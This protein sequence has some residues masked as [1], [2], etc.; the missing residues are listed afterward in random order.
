MS[1]HTLTCTFCKKSEHD[2]RKL[3]AGPGVYIC[4][5]CVEIAH[6]IVTGSDAA[7]PQPAWSSRVACWIR[8]RLPP[9][10]R[11]ASAQRAVQPT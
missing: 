3:V 2:V 8:A 10:G 7:A 5:A 9:L 4:D 1:R 11:R 6:R